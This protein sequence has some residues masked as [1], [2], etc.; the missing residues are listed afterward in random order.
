MK[1]CKIPRKKQG[2]IGNCRNC[3]KQGHYAKDCRGGNRLIREAI[4]EGETRKGKPSDKKVMFD[5]TDQDEGNSSQDF[6]DDQ[7]RRQS[8]RSKHTTW[9][10]IVIVYCYWRKI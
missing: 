2:F 5:L 9:T 4:A 10:Q 7:E 3:G 1:E 6:P 8:S